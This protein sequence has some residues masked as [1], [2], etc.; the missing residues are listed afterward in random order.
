MLNTLPDYKRHALK[1]RRAQ[2][3]EEYDAIMA[4][5]SHT[6]SAADELKLKR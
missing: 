6:L 4:Q 1:S 5:L 3:I 2:L